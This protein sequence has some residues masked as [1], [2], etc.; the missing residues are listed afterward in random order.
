[1][2]QV[3]FSAFLTTVEVMKK[4]LPSVFFGLYLANL[5]TLSNFLHRAGKYTPIISK[6][7]GLSLA[8]AG[9]VIVSIGDRTAGMSVLAMVRERSALTEKEIVAANLVAK[10]PSVLQF[11]VFSF[12]P[13]MFSL[14]PSNIAIRFLA[15]YFLAFLLI[16]LIGVIY[17]KWLP[18]GKL[19]QVCRTTGGAAKPIN[20]EVVKQAA[21]DTWPRFI[22]VAC[23][24]SG[25]SFLSMMLIKSGLL[26]GMLF[27]LSGGGWVV[28]GSV[29]SLA[30]LGMISMVGGAAAAGAAFSAGTIGEGVIVPLLLSM[31]VLHNCY[32]LLA[33]S[34]PRYVGI[35]GRKTGIKLA[36]SGFVVTQ[37]V[38][39]LMVF[40]SAQ[41]WL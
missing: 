32:D 41:D 12:I 4:A 15:I 5:A 2:G 17:A 16:S 25:M 21:A 33:S 10:A 35:F 18:G 14:Y 24:M 27:S 22:R 6:V 31:S 9:S 8:A 39:I 40:V 23:W 11:F 7:T 30:G 28:D 19:E 3:A 26:N 20:W 13:I 29:L 38:M 34:I 37:I 1:M 36:L